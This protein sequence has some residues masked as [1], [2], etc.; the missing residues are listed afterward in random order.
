MFARSL[1]SCD[2]DLIKQKVKI[3]N[4]QTICNSIGYEDSN[5]ADID[6]YYQIWKL[7]NTWKWNCVKLCVKS[8]VSLQFFQRTI[9]DKCKKLLY[10]LLLRWAICDMYRSSFITCEIR[11]LWLL[12]CEIYQLW[13][14][15]CEI[16]QLWLLTCEFCQL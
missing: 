1:W 11:Q 8:L 15:T 16:R 12:T 3:I 5:F 4:F 7:W 9:L 14:L 2:Q 13:L 6:K 10:V